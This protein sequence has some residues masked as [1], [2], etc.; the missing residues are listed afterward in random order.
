[1][2]LQGGGWEEWN[3]KSGLERNQQAGG[4][5]RIRV[6]GMPVGSPLP[7]LNLSPPALNARLTLAAIARL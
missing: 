2:D 7:P 6:G 5:L 4:Q 3:W 1:M